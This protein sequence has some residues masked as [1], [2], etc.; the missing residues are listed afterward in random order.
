M[1]LSYRVVIKPRYVK[2]ETPWLDDAGAE[3]LTNIETQTIKQLLKSATHPR[4][5]AHGLLTNLPNRD[6]EITESISALLLGV[7]WEDVKG[8]PYGPLVPRCVKS[9]TFGFGFGGRV[10]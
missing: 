8:K 1:K 2:L 5:L 6:I 9:A 7:S 3:V 10:G 4:Y